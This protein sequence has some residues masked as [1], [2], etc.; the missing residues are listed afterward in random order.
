[1]YSKS[2]QNSSEANFN[3]RD[4]RRERRAKAVMKTLAVLTVPSVGAYLAQDK[5][6][7]GALGPP[8][9]IYTLKSSSNVLP[10]E[11]KATSEGTELCAGSTVSITTEIDPMYTRT[12]LDPRKISVRI[13]GSKFD[14]YKI[15][16]KPFYQTADGSTE[17]LIRDIAKAQTLEGIRGDYNVSI[18]LNKTTKLGAT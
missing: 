9:S 2:S 5:I 3:K 13:D 12:P 17:F 6:L 14:L 18:G 8:D 11:S 15:S 7:E 16:D 4:A 1:M 10:S